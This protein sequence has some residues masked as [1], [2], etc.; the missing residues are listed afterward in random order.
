M[1]VSKE[2]A[3]KHRAAIVTQ[4]SQLFR[5]HGFDGVGL[6]E[7]MQAAGLTH[8]GFYG[9]FASKDAL[10]AEASAKALDDGTACIARDADLKAYLGRYLTERHRDSSGL[11]C[12]MAALAAEVG[13]HDGEVQ[14]RFAGAMA[15]YIAAIEALLQR[16]G[17][18]KG[19]A[20]RRRA[21][22]LVSALVGG[23]ALARASAAADP[24]LSL[25]ILAAL[26]SELADFAAD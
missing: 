19:P 15:A 16:S 8:G 9:H 5:E 3:A 11:G 22:A 4:A 14:A 6:A 25:E 18:R 24:D 1:K 17:A 23:M 2:T 7:I 26:R 21:I 13:R 10:A 12:P 20:T